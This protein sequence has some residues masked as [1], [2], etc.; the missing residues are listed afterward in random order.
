MATAFKEHLDSLDISITE[1]MVSTIYPMGDYYAL[2]TQHNTYEAD[3]IILAPGVFTARTFPGEDDYLGKGV[4]YC[5]T[6]D[7]P[8]Y[9]D[10]TVAI[11]GYSNG[12]VQ[13]ANFMAD[14]AKK[15]YYIPVGKLERTPDPRVEVVTDRVQ[16]IK[17][18]TLANT[19]V[20]KDQTL[21]VDG[22]FILR[23]NIAPTALLPGLALDGSYIKVNEAMETNL[24]GCFAAGDCTGQ[25]HQYIRAAGQ[26]LVAGFSAVDYL[27][28][29]DKAN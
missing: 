19:L 4:G 12:A 10:K 2:A 1:E 21:A 14:V 17:G 20:L 11:V 29:Q 9:K 27:A 3:T 25:P 7:A 6:C 23:D 26:G 16:E 22:I 24:P 15:V 18:D 13:E 8:L 5:A 28:A